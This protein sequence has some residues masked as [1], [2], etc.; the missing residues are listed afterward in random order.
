MNETQ[1]AGKSKVDLDSYITWTRNRT[2][3]GGGGIA[4]AVSVEFRDSACGAGEGQGDDEYLI[5]RLEAFNP[6][7]CVINCYGEQRSRSSKEEVEARW[8]RLRKELEAVR[9]RGE[10]CLLTGDLNKLVGSDSLGVPGNNSEVSPCGRLLRDLLA[11]GDWV[12]VNGLGEEVVT[13]GPFTRQDPAT[14]KESCLDLF[15][16]SS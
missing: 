7:L 1:L 12:L 6:A 10:F 11:G 15:V 13:G 3:Q 14:G 8:G 2:V 9:A 4:T 5:T 16:V